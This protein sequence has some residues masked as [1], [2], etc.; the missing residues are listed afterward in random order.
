MKRSEVAGWS[1]AHTAKLKGD[2]T[3]SQDRAILNGKSRAE[4]K[5]RDNLLKRFG[6]S[7]GYAR[8]N[9][10]R[11]IRAELG[12]VGSNLPSAIIPVEI[13]EAKMLQ[14]KVKQAVRRKSN[15]S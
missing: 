1:K 11:A 12:L 2:Q 10:V 14:M 9:A 8:Y 5:A 6:G 4:K 3:Y 7:L 13:I 15:R